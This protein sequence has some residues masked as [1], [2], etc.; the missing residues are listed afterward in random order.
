MFELFESVNNSAE[1]KE[2]AE[3]KKKKRE[4]RKEKEKQM[5]IQEYRI[6][7]LCLATVIGLYLILAIISW[8]TG[9]TW[10]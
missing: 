2:T 6:L 1:R 7:F 9:F 3:L 10:S 4:R 8:L 5:K